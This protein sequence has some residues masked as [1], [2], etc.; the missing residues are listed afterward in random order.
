MMCNPIVNARAPPMV[1]VTEPMFA[2]L[3]TH[4]A[5]ETTPEMVQGPV[6]TPIVVGIVSDLPDPLTIGFW[7][8]LA[9]ADC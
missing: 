6:P 9:S 3:L 7:S 2:S 8:R 1:P 5:E 4:P